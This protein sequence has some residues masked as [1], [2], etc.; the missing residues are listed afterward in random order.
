[1]QELRLFSAPL[2][3]STSASREKGPPGDPQSASSPSRPHHTG[4]SAK[5][6]D[7]PSPQ[8]PQATQKTTLPVGSRPL[9]THTVASCCKLAPVVSSQEESV[10]HCEAALRA[11]LSRQVHGLP[12][13]GATGGQEAWSRSPRKER[14][15]QHSIPAYRQNP[16]CKHKANPAASQPPVCAP[17]KPPY[18]SGMRPKPPILTLQDCPNLAFTKPHPG[19]AQPY[20]TLVLIPS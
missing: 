7:S 16:S 12:H 14:L 9:H 11:K 20:T 15:C 17:P 13:E 10:D 5:L 4:A 6:G 3:R 18:C 2:P 19:P 1:M 8:P